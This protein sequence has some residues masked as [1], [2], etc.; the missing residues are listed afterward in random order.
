MEI[1][2]NILRDLCHIYE[3]VNSIQQ[4]D[5]DI[6]DVLVDIH[7]YIEKYRELAENNAS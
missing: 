6:E 2:L 1:K 3:L 4:E 5:R 7:G